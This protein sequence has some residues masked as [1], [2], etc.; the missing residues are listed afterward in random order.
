MTVSLASYPS[1]LSFLCVLLYGIGLCDFGLCILDGVC[2]E[3]TTYHGRGYWYTRYSLS[4]SHTFSITIFSRVL[5]FSHLRLCFTRHLSRCPFDLRT[6]E[7]L[8]S[9]PRPQQTDSRYVIF[10]STPASPWL[11]SPLTVGMVKVPSV[12]SPLRLSAPFYDLNANF[13][14]SFIRCAA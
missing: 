6:S 5:D 1:L 2:M 8:P 12:V 3:W 9:F 7:Q 10:D 4:L 13:F 14:L 11:D